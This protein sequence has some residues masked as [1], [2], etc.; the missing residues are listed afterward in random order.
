MSEQKDTRFQPGHSGNPAGRPA[1][2]RNRATL[3]REEA[4]QERAQ[5]YAERIAEAAEQ[6]CEL[7]FQRAQAGSIPAARLLIQTL[8]ARR[9]MVVD[10]PDVEGGIDA[11]LNAGSELIRATAAGELSPADALLLQRLLLSQARLLKIA[12]PKPPAASAPLVP[13]EPAGARPPVTGKKQENTGCPS[14]TR[15][16]PMAEWLAVTGMGERLK[17]MRW[18]P[19]DAPLPLVA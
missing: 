15:F 19:A 11:V 16:L 2:A 13:G 7:T 8:L 12:G 14:P 6:V 17:A 9:P 1:G 18:H 4:L 5:A 3:A 10:L